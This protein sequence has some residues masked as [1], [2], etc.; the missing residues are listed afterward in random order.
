ML[1]PTPPPRPPHLLP[2]PPPSPPPPPMIFSPPPPPPLPPG[3]VAGNS[4]PQK[5]S[6]DGSESG[7]SNRRFDSR[8]RPGSKSRD[9]QDRQSTRQQRKMH[10]RNYYEDTMPVAANFQMSSKYHAPLGQHGEPL[11]I[12]VKVRGLGNRGL[13]ESNLPGPWQWPEQG[14]YKSSDTSSEL[15][16]RVI[17]ARRW[18]DTESHHVLD[19]TCA[20]SSDD[21]EGPAVKTMTW[22]HVKSPSLD[23]DEFRTIVLS[24]PGLSNNWKIVLL[25]LLNRIRQLHRIH[26]SNHYF[27]WVMRADSS[28]MGLN[29]K[30]DAILS[31]TSVS[32]PYFTTG[33]LQGHGS[34][35]T[36]DQYPSMSLFEWDSRFE[37]AKEWDSEQIYRIMSDESGTKDS[38]I[39]VPHLWSVI[40]DRT[41]ITYGPVA[42]ND[43]VNDKAANMHV[44]YLG[45]KTSLKS[46]HVADLHGL[47][48]ELPFIECRTFFALKQSIQVR[49]FAHAPVSFEEIDILLY[50]KIVLT[51]EVWVRTLQQHKDEIINL[52]LRTKRN[53]SKRKSRHAKMKSAA[54]NGSNP[55]STNVKTSS[56]PTKLAGDDSST[57]SHSEYN[58]V[59]SKAA[60]AAQSHALVLYNSGYSVN[61]PTSYPRY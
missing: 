7:S 49:C 16:L 35:D 40:F 3:A 60:I 48:H 12:E 59:S 23:F 34:K 24:R 15:L 45:T 58:S 13:L 25:S 20:P 29:M 57:N 19:M 8:G 22:L 56:I 36:D 53:V 1:P 50:G 55:P 17:Q 26:G 33:P 52:K 51:G 10:R 28:E 27:P 46:I 5:S 6:R 31:A 32:F 39:Y 42:F 9:Q 11:W 21:T 61:C 4:Y 37:S 2:P 38:I 54:P 30:S 14:E 41:I 18:F 47:E 44:S 43:I